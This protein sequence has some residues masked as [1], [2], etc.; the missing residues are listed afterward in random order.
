MVDNVLFFNTPNSNL[1]SCGGKGLN[2]VR[3]YQS[4]FPVPEGFILTTSTYWSYI[5]DNQLQ[6]V[7]LKTLDDLSQIDVV[8][9]PEELDKSS[10][11]IR[12]EFQKGR[13]PN[14][15][16]KELRQGF[17]QLGNG[18]FAVRSSATAED[19]PE[20]SF[21]GQQETYLNVLGLDALKIAVVNCWSN[22]WTGRAIGYRIRN[23]LDQADLSLAVIVQTMVQT[24][25]SGVLF[26]AN[27]LTG[28][29]S[30]MV[31][32]ATLGL[33]EALVSGK[34]DPDQYT[35][36]RP[37]NG[38]MFIRSKR[39]GDKALTLTGQAKG[40]VRS[41]YQP[42]NTIQALSDAEILELSLLGD[43]VALHFG[44]PQDLE[45]G[46]KDRK[47][48]LLQTRPITSLYPLPENIRDNTLEVLGSF[49]AVQGML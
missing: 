29:R 11:L 3:M 28:R 21:A 2:L 15:I 36:D 7:I 39:L 48:Y 12:S 32:D 22:L 4:G 14:V 20:L 8:A 16:S 43:Q 44:S 47:L 10:G 24:D 41:S 38:K 37:K 34:V 31:I 27:P 42:K 9:H 19:L 46:I 13:F 35:V 23:G 30:Q 1:A 6:P 18:L 5:Q 25:S 45:W 49:G 33:G 40:G 17:N 26:T